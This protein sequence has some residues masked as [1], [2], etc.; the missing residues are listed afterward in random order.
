[1]QSCNFRS[2]EGANS[3]PLPPC[4]RH[5]GCTRSSERPSRSQFRGVWLVES[6]GDA[7]KESFPGLLSLE[8]CLANL[9]FTPFCTGPKTCPAWESL[10]YRT[11]R[12]GASQGPVLV[13]LACPALSRQQTNNQ[14]HSASSHRGESYNVE[15]VPGREKSPRPPWAS[16]QDTGTCFCRCVVIIGC[17][18]S[19]TTADNERNQAHKRPQPNNSSTAEPECT[20]AARAAGSEILG[21][22]FQM[23][24]L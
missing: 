4:C 20:W 8:P 15:N 2:E 18:T 1:M 16:W 7:S 6:Q 19:I 24:W 10:L 9:Q 11:E 3:S 17:T 23:P 22:H 14:T 12:D 21:Q 5:E 13:F